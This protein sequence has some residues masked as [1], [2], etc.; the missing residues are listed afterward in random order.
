MPW[1]LFF[2]LLGGLG[3]VLMALVGLGHGTHA[4][5]HAGS[6]AHS[7][8]GGHAASGH[9]AS[10]HAA[11]ASGHAG[12]SQSSHAVPHAHQADG[13]SLTGTLSAYALD[14][15]SP[16]VFFSLS[17]GLGL[18]G[19]MLSVLAPAPRALAAVAGGL[20]FER[21]LINPLWQL[22]FRFASTPATNLDHCLSDT[23][24]AETS[25]NAD[26]DGLVLL[27]V[28]GQARQLLGRLA[29]P[30]LQLGVRVRRGDRLRVEAVDTVRN[31][32]TVSTLTLGPARPGPDA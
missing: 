31:R 13:F 26:G 6:H 24:T 18:T 32:C 3:L 17:L 27:S 9:A 20:V 19:L 5:S 15:L 10:G 16:R 2:A 14:L 11:S 1:Y 29:A 28:D 8:P 30:D 4:G 21:L 25:F 7:G 23:V 22:L 12:A